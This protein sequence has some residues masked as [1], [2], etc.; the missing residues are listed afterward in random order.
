VSGLLA[1]L[2]PVLSVSVVEGLPL[3]EVA[4][5]TRGRRVSRRARPRE[6]STPCCCAIYLRL[7]LVRD[8]SLVHVLH[9]RM[10]FHGH[11]RYLLVLHRLLQEFRIYFCRRG[12]LDSPNLD[13]TT[14]V[15]ASRHSSRL[16]HLRRDHLRRTAHDM[17]RERVWMA[18]DHATDLFVYLLDGCHC[19]RMQHILR[20]L[21]G[22]GA[23]FP[24]PNIRHHDALPANVFP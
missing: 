22:D 16:E 15:A 3:V 12:R 1:S 17:A 9:L 21:L 18:W 7:Q 19:A 11:W 6:V 20:S 10:V 4:L 5:H 14:A 8:P 24:L 23:C 13:I 2:T